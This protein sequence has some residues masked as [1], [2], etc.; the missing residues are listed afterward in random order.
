MKPLRIQRRRNYRHPVVR[1]ECALVGMGGV[2][3]RLLVSR[4]SFFGIVRGSRREGRRATVRRIA[5]PTVRRLILLRQGPAY[6]DSGKNRCRRDLPPI[7]HSPILMP[8]FPLAEVTD[9]HD[10]QPNDRIRI[11][12][13]LYQRRKSARRREHGAPKPIRSRRLTAA[14]CR[15]TRHKVVDSR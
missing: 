13:F 4:D 8:I 5:I 3:L 11:S 12:P 9:V 14:S 1:I 15:A 2:A 6:H 7:P 10:P